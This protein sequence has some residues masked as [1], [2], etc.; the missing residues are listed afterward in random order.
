M[1]ENKAQTSPAKAGVP[2]IKVNSEINF[3]GATNYRN[4]NR[5]FGI[6]LDDR[7]RHMYV[8][9][10]TGMGKTTIL[11]NMVLNDIYAGHGVGVVDPHGDFAEKIIN[12]VP[13]NRI[14]DVVY[15]NP[16][17]IDYPIGFNIL[18]TIRPEQKH[19]VASGLMGVFKKIWPDV[20]S[21]RM[22]YILNN[23][24]L[25]LLDFPGT[26]LLGI[27]RML[28]DAEYRKRVVNNTQD[29][30]IKA[31]WQTEFANYSDKF[32]SEAVSPIQ[33]KIGQF[34]SAS[35]IRNIVAQVKSRINIR[36]IMDERKI[37]IMNLSKG[38]IGE[39]NSRLLGGMLITKIQLSAMERV[40]IPEEQRK[41]FFLYVDE[42]QNFATE[43]FAN[44]LSE[45]RKYRLDLIMAH[46]Y[47]LQLDEKVLASVIGNVGSMVTFRVGST[48]AEILAKEFAPTFIEEDLVN[49]PKFQTYLKL[50]IDGVASRPFSATTLPPIGS[51]TASADKVIRVSRERYATNREK[52]EE[53]IMRWSGMMVSGDDANDLDIDDDE[54]TFKH[55]TPVPGNPKPARPVGGSEAPN[56]KQIPSSNVKTSTATPPTQSSPVKVAPPS[57]QPYPVQAR[58]AVSSP[59]QSRPMPQATQPPQGGQNFGGQ[60]GSESGGNRKRKRNRNQSSQAPVG[61]AEP[62]ILGDPNQKGLSLSQVMNGS[63]NRNHQPQQQ[64]GGQQQPRQSQPARPPQS[65]PVPMNAPEPLD[66]GLP[67]D[68]S[69]VAL[70]K[71]EAL[72][73]AGIPI[74]PP[75]PTKLPQ[76]ANPLDSFKPSPEAAALLGFLDS[77]KLTTQLPPQPSPPKANPQPSRPPELPKP[78]VAP[79]HQL[80]DIPPGRVVKIED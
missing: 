9:G 11:E 37:F 43:S 62:V 44:I 3:F 26:T 2:V 72:A 78:S 18:E 38:R 76:P 33:N 75:E 73:Q 57:A 16:S 69:T 17:D 59:S 55:P 54:V 61:S 39:D 47:M 20:W 64:S 51:P 71:V 56:P 74:P 27:N 14:N 45:A 21:A 42:F 12:Y 40:D 68:V 70:A 53:K 6:K 60:P 52:I 66:L 22:E 5:K 49:L 29:P 36:E 7:R 15:F 1:E 67:A 79:P 24:I 80:K 34:L 30:V 28:A 50:M 58:P 46:Q 4:Q 10:K 31:Y 48:D 25:A 65:S 13:P 23:T 63:Q 19:L 32:R 41:D 35:V 8:V 77:N